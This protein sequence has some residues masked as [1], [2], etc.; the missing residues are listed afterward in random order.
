MQLHQQS[1]FLTKEECKFFIDFHNNNFFKLP[2]L[3]KE[4]HRD[5][6][7]IHYSK[8]IRED[9]FNYIY[10]KI[11]YF[12]QSINKN[13]YPNYVQIVKWPE[14]SSQI[15][16]KD[17]DYHPFTSIIYLNDD[18]D[19]GETFVEDKVIKKE[20]GKI[21]GFEGS[22]LN[23][24]VNKINKGTRFTIPIWYKDIYGSK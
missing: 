19:G 4:I 18:Y 24:G 20:T 3:F 1:N 16:H 11:A 12:I 8:L 2:Q 23:H 17:F 14:Q 9:M 21:V 22:K 13:Y 6:E 15:K 5:T 7:V 10:C